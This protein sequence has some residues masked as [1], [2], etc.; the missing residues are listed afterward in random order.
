MPVKYNFIPERQLGL[1]PPEEKYKVSLYQNSTIIF[2]SSVVSIYDLNN[3]FIRLF[4]DTEKKL[5][6][7]S[8]IEGDTDLDT[9]KDARQLKVSVNGNIVVSVGRLLKAMNYELAESLKGLEV[10]KF[11]STLTNNTI[12][13]IELPPKEYI[14]Q[15]PKQESNEGDSQN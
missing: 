9:L 10:K 12:W 8:I 7:W 2:S 3:K 6:G 11:K 14:Y 13:Y 4:A 1:P 5:I 15:P